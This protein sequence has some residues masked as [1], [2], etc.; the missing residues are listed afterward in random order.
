MPEKQYETI[1]IQLSTYEAN[2]LIAALRLAEDYL[3]NNGSNN[4][5]LLLEHIPDLKLRHELVQH[6]KNYDGTPLYDAA[7][8][9]YLANIIKSQVKER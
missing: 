4:D 6:L 1:T 9:R 7:L 3:N 5:F 8:M 2:L